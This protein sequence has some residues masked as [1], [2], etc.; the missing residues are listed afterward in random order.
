MKKTLIP[1]L[2]LISLA[3]KG[4]DL[5]S[6]KREIVALK[7]YQDNLQFNLE[8]YDNQHSLGTSLLLGGLILTAVDLAIREKD[9]SYDTPAF[10]IV[11]SSCIVAGTVLTIDA[12]KYIGRGGKRRKK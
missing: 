9:D 7:L 5:D 4:Q 3:S 8:K 1:L 12:R 6:L 10:L 11:S 2:V